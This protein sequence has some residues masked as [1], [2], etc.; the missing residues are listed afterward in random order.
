[1][2]AFAPTAYLFD[3][4]DDWISADLRQRSA[5]CCWRRTLIS[6]QTDQTSVLSSSFGGLW[7]NRNTTGKGRSENERAALKFKVQISMRNSCIVPQNHT[8]EQQE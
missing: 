5:V 1:M 2:G 8:S 7:W 4:Q 3:V 6:R